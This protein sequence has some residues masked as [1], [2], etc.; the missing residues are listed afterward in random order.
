VSDGH[1]SGTSVEVSAAIGLAA[2]AVARCLIGSSGGSIATAAFNFFRNM[3]QPKSLKGRNAVGRK[4]GII[5][6]A[7]DVIS[8]EN[9]VVNTRPI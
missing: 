8:K 1:S 6:I 4:R 5:V 2:P 7:E 3:S 9:T